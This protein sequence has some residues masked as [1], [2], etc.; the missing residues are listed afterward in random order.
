MPDRTSK[1]AGRVGGQVGVSLY[2]RSDNEQ[3]KELIKSNLDIIVSTTDREKGRVEFAKGWIPDL[4]GYDG[5][6]KIVLRN[7]LKCLDKIA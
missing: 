3:S 6:P 1:P 2:L 5:Q 7:S 4:V